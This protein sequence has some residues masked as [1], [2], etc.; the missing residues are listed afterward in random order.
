[1]VSKITLIEPHFDGAQ[2]GPAS[3]PGDEAER[4]ESAATEVPIESE[5]PTGSSRSR[6]L[7]A[8][9]LVTVVAVLAAVASRR[10]SG[11]EADDGD[12]EAEDAD[13]IVIE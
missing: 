8:A 9:G 5:E 13:E 12:A 2:F 6:W 7:L 1:M 11:E 4:P 3:M 10:R